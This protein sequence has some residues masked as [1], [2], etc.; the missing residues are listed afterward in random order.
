MRGVAK[1]FSHL[2]PELLVLSNYILTKHL[3]IFEGTKS[4]GPIFRHQDRTL[5]NACKGFGKRID[6]CESKGRKSFL[7]AVYVLTMVNSCMSRHASD[8]N[9]SNFKWKV[10][11]LLKLMSPFYAVFTRK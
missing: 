4:F 3:N 1:L 9:F 8:D 10:M 2:A 7:S 5:G 6:T 11:M